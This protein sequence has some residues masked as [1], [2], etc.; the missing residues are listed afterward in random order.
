MA[1]HLLT[2]LS[3]KEGRR[4]TSKALGASV[5]THPVVIRRILQSLRASGLVETHKGAG[6]GSILARC[7]AEITLGQIYRAV[8][9]EEPFL[10][11]LR[12]PRQD[13]PVGRRLK[14]VLKSVFASVETALESELNKT[15]LQDLCEA[16]NSRGESPRPPQPTALNLNP[17]LQS[18]ESSDPPA[19]PAH[20]RRKTNLK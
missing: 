2:V 9:K 3:C 20:Q 14:T 11:P 19:K 7:P 5:N 4:G 15:S 10:L 8:E 17:N 18:P 13:C 12:E 16:L 1:V 6:A